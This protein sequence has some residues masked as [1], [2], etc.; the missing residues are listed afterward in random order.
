M[1][2]Q[3]E[4]KLKLTGI[5]LP[6]V[7]IGKKKAVM[8]ARKQITPYT[9]TVLWNEA[10]SKTWNWQTLLQLL[11]FWAKLIVQILRAKDKEHDAFVYVC[12]T[13]S[14]WHARYLCYEWSNHGAYPG[15]GTAAPK[16]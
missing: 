15:T 8:A 16:T 6:I 2:K 14:F 4:R 1:Q 13:V 10:F 12:T 3:K 11:K 7:S 9:Y 5:S